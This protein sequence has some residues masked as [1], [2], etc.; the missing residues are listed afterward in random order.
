[1]RNPWG[2]QI[3]SN[4]YDNRKGGV[5]RNYWNLAYERS[6]PERL[7][8]TTRYKVKASELLDHP[9]TQ[10]L[11]RSR[12]RTFARR[13]ICGESPGWRR[14]PHSNP[15]YNKVIY[16]LDKNTTEIQCLV[17]LKTQERQKRMQRHLQ[18]LPMATFM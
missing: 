6:V 1:M 14:R 15:N 7:P 3:I 17:W 9:P 18:E 13:C 10:Q 2:K 12:L 5:P 16:R 8:W 4:R 11:A